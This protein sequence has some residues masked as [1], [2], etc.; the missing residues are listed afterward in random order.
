ME[1]LQLRYYAAVVEAGSMSGAARALNM[2]QPPLSMQIKQLET[3]LGCVLFERG[4]RNIR[5]TEEGRL[6]YEHSVRILN[7][8]ESASAAV[9]NCHNAETGTL[10]VGVVSSLAN[11]AVEKWFKGFAKLYPLVN[12]ELTEGSTYEILDKLGS[13]ILDVGLVRTPFSARGFACVSLPPQDM[14]LVGKALYLKEAVPSLSLKQAAGLPL[15]V[16][17]RW[18]EVLDRAFAAKGCKP[19]ILCVADDARTCIAWAAA[20]L[21]VAVVPAD[22]LEVLPVLKLQTAVLRGLVPAAEA[23]LAVN[24]GGCDTA[25]GRKFVEY[26]RECCGV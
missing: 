25:V 14:L 16:Y 5:L 8:A 9:A 17:R 6:F 13:R 7:M 18:S 3:E 26:F 22:I 1:L 23:T 2:T 15:I 21:G 24:E 11:L 12:Y 4:S 20:D 19:R 10:R